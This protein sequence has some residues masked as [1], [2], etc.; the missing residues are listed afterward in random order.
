MSS[1]ESDGLGGI[2]RPLTALLGAILLLGGCGSGEGPSQAPPEDTAQVAAAVEDTG[3][4]A[5]SAQPAAAQIPFQPSGTFPH[6]EHRRIECTTCHGRPPGH[7]T[8]AT[9]ACTDCHGVPQ[10]YATLPVR[11]REQCMSC[12]HDPNRGVSCDHCHGSAPR[13]ALEVQTSVRMSVW[14]GERPRTLSFE[15]ERHDSLACRTCHANPPSND[16]TRGCDSCHR[17]HHNPDASCG[18]CH[19][20]DAVEHHDRSVHLG[21]GGS[22]C[23]QDPAVLALPPTRSLCLV[24]HADKADHEE[25]KVCIDCHLV[26]EGGPAGAPL[27]GGRP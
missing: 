13:G 12:H 25:G 15:H 27:S 24:C 21:C 5:V 8:H 14:E 19:A 23:H 11:N 2:G 1:E 9:V 18:S 10:D 16:F 20:P 22:G 7:A 6:G 4:V 26:T 3:T 17:Q